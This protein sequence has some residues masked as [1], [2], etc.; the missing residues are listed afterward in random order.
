MYWHI[1][2]VYDDDDDDDDGDNDNDDDVFPIWKIFVENFMAYSKATKDRWL[3]YQQTL[4]KFLMLLPT[5]ILHLCT[6]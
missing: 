3:A 4:T 1:D 5:Y 6:R 2:K